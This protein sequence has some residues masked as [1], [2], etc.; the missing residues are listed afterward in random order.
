MPNGV[1]EEPIIPNPT[2]SPVTTQHP[3][4]RKEAFLRSISPI[5]PLLVETVGVT[6]LVATLGASGQGFVT[7]AMALGLTLCAWRRS[8]AQFNPGVVCM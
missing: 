6:F 5:A 4:N 1:K 7:G 2:P 3:N 8:G